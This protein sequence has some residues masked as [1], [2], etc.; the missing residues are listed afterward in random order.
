MY[1]VITDF[2]FP[3]LFREE[4]VI[5]ISSPGLIVFKDC[6]DFE[7]AEKVR[8]ASTHISRNTDT[9]FIKSP[10]DFIQYEL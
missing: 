5:L 6:F 2:H 9:R 1:A 3:S 7:Q 10:P 4:E 8:I